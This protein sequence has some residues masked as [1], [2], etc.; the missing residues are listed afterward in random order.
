M[1]L[2]IGNFRDIECNGTGYW[3]N[4][5]P[6]PSCTR[7]TLQ[8]CSI[9]SYPS[10]LPVP[11]SNGASYWRNP[12]PA[13]SHCTLQLCSIWLH[14]PNFQDI[15]AFI[16]YPFQILRPQ[17]VRLFHLETLSTLTPIDYHVQTENISIELTK[18]SM[19]VS[20][21][22]FPNEA[23]LG[24]WFRWTGHQIV[25]RGKLRCNIRRLCPL[26]LSFL[27]LILFLLLMYL[28]LKSFIF[29]STYHWNWVVRNLQAP[30]P[31][32]TLKQHQARP[33]V[34]SLQGM[35]AA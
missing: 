12:E 35:K 11:S 21:W 1:H 22:F 25:Q 26:R 29:T 3:R 10:Q 8:F 28:Y 9:W 7:C 33:L 34:Y 19:Y 27:S 6:A 24:I 17:W 32:Y 14:L 23:W 4:P 13:P 30:N 18:L 20:S 5:K 31:L 15:A 16:A 2:L